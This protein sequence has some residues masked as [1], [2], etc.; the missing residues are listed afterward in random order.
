MR[1][2]AK[3]YLGQENGIDSWVVL[4]VLQDSHTLYLWRGAMDVELIKLFRVL[5]LKFD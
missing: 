3:V 1:K 5:L 4:E 2:H